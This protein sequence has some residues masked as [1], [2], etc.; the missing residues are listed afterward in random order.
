[1]I[2]PAGFENAQGIISGGFLK[3]ASDPSMAEDP[4]VKNYLAFVAK[5]Y[6]NADITTTANAQGYVM[7]QLLVQVLKQSGDDL[8][9]ANVMR[10]AAN[11]KQT[12]FDMLM[13]GIRISTS[14]DDFAPVKSMQL[15][16]IA[17]ERWQPF[18][19]VIELE[20]GR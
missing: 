2:R 10:Q 8:T 13:P 1:V 18:G 4:G 7:S 11:I 12:E 20:P 16:R 3:D 9:R 19:S 15:R 5:F 6:T 17:G 14:P